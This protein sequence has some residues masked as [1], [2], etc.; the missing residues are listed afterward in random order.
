MFPK[1]A[2]SALNLVL[3]MFG[4]GAFFIP[5]AAQVNM[6]MLSLPLTWN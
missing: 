4:V 3:A 2:G 6:R 5:L 1:R